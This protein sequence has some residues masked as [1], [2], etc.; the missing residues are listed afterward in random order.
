MNR[1]DSVV[2]QLDQA[3]EEAL[4][5]R[6]GAAVPAFDA[7]PAV[8]LAALQDA[9]RRLDRVEELLAASLRIK[10]A[11]ERDRSLAQARLDD[12]WDTKINEARDGRRGVAVIRER[13]EFSSAK[14]RVAEANLATLEL[15]RTAREATDIHTQ[16]AAQVDVLRLVH[17]GLDGIRHDLLTTLRT[18]AFEST[19]DR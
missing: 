3:V 16:C 13:D 4:K 2:R 18:L 17:R 12:E 10:A 19:L 6:F 11:A 8:V 15:R 9:R 14:E 5:L 1:Y 7:D